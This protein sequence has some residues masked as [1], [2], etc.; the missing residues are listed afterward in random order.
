MAT[1]ALR[2]AAARRMTA[3]RIAAS[4]ICLGTAITLFMMLITNVRAAGP[5]IA[6]QLLGRHVLESLG[7]ACR[8]P[9]PAQNPYRD[10]STLSRRAI[11]ERLDQQAALARPPRQQPTALATHV[12]ED[13]NPLRVPEHETR[14]VAPP[15]V[16]ARATVEPQRLAEPVMPPRP[17]VAAE[18]TSSEPAM[19]FASDQADVES[20]VA[21]SVSL[22]QSTPLVASNTPAAVPVV[23]Q[24]TVTSTTSPIANNT[25]AHLSTATSKPSKVEAASGWNRSAAL[26]ANPLRSAEPTSTGASTLSPGNPLRK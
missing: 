20:P 2:R 1:Q 15:N 16:A 10:L 7:R 21:H 4:C 22:P 26:A 23:H 14:Q 12:A 13:R 19:A 18:T 11:I 9:A 3:R 25:P 17:L 8:S 6:R 5:E 24:E